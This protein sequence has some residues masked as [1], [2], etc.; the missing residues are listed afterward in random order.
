MKAT[1]TKDEVKRL[2]DVLNWVNTATQDTKESR[3]Q[4]RDIMT[5]LRIMLKSSPEKDEVSVEIN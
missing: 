3:E 2:L 5:K 4:M 1:F